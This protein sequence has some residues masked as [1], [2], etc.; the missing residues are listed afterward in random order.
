MAMQT[1]SGMTRVKR[2]RSMSK[3]PISRPLNPTQ[4]AY[5]SMAHRRQR[6]TSA[7]PLNPATPMFAKR[8]NRIK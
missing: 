8:S 2:V 6:G 7:S 1:N 3:S 5:V 4:R